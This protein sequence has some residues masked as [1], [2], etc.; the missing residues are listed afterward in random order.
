MAGDRLELHRKLVEALESKNVY[1]QPPNNLKINYPAI[2]YSR[3]GMNLKHAD[4]VVYSNKR[5]YS[6]MLIDR[7]PD[8]IVIDRLL[9]L[10]YCSYNNH[11]TSDNLHHDVFEI[12]F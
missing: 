3:D 6:V 2:V 11:F 1:F 10:Q 5:R 9:T 8:S 4:D 12:Y 7:T